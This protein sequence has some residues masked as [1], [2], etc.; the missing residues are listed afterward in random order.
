M[1]KVLI[2]NRGEIAVRVIRACKE[3][4]LPTVVLGGPGDGEALERIRGMANSEPLS[5]VG[6]TSLTQAA[7]A[8]EKAALV[9]GV[10]TGLTHAAH[11][12]RR[13]TICMFGPSGYTQPPT[14]MSRMVRYE[15]ACAP[16]T[17]RGGRPTCGGAFTCMDL[18]TGREVM[19][20][21]RDLMAT[22]PPG[23]DG[24]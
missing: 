19:D 7:G 15:L 11:A 14:P 1:E 8:I 17:P 21:A 9:V 16:C 5:L 18:I 24:V 10:D 2:A 20:V 6:R 3:L 13:P 12:F 22:Y 4:G 23:R